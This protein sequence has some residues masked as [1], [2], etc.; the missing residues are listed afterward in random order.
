[1]SSG[2]V[3]K[4]AEVLRFEDIHIGMSA[5]FVVTVVSSMLEIFGTI[6]GDFNP[7]HV[8][9]EYAHSIGHPGPVVYGMLTSSFYSRL[10][11]MHIPG[12]HALL[13]QIEV[14]FTAPV[15]IGDI[16]TVEGYV[17]G[18]HESVQ[19]IEI[20]ASITNQTRK[21]ISTAKIKAGMYA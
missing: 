5:S 1:V 12:K 2:G 7:L 11:G 21:Q 3:P 16:L 6:C 8:D 17:S 9:A 18:I 14:G 19:Q 20:K 13:Q 15:Y 10:V 4:V